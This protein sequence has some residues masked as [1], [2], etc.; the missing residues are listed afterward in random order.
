MNNTNIIIEY[1]PKITEPMNK[2][3]KLFSFFTSIGELIANCQ[4]KV[5]T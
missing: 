1:S 3:K 2:L 4:E 5:L